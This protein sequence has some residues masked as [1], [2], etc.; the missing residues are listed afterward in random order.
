MTPAERKNY[1]S[2]EAS[3]PAPLSYL[4]T[5]KF[6]ETVNR[7]AKNSSRAKIFDDFLKCSAA[8]LNRDEKTFAEVA[9]KNLHCEL[10]ATLANALEW[11]ITFK[12]LFAHS[13]GNDALPMYRDILGEIF[14]ELELF[15]QGGGQVLTPQQTADI[16]GATTLTAEL[17][18]REIAQCGYVTIKENCC[19]SGA[20][21]LGACNALLDLGVNPCR[22]ARVQ[23]S[24]LDERCVLM[25]FIQLSLYGI[26]AVVLRQNA[27]TDEV[28]GSPLV[29]PILKKTNF[30]LKPNTSFFNYVL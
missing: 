28:V 22:Q 20:L 3:R 16:M 1:Y 12:V 30:T 25:T 13:L 26:P 24:D 2:K 27:V 7:A 21:I 6:V 5:K 9:D 19:G 17:V 15:D 23:A 29:T 10:F 4:Y 14:C 18:K 11:S 8:A